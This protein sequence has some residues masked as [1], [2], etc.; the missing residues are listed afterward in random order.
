MPWSTLLD[1]D[2]I[3]QARNSWVYQSGDVFEIDS[4]QKNKYAIKILNV[5]NPNPASRVIVND[6]RVTFSVSFFE[7]EERLIISGS[8]LKTKHYSVS[9][10]GLTPA[11]YTV[12][13][14]RVTEDSTDTKVID[15]VYVGSIRAAKN[16]PP[17]RSEVVPGLTLIELKIKATEKLNNVVDR[18]NFIAQS[19]LPVSV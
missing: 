13:I 5:D 19:K 16:V 1:S 17:V 9:R 18:L 15:D 3:W 11:S 12:K 7:T 2:K 6:N 8:E 4:A 14:S 10:S